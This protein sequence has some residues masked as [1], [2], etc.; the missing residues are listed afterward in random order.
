[1]GGEIHSKE[2]TTQRK[3]NARIFFCSVRRT[4][5]ER[6]IERDYVVETRE[7]EKYRQTERKRERARERERKETRPVLTTFKTRVVV[8]LSTWVKENYKKKKTFHRGWQKLL[9]QS[10]SKK[11]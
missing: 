3:E 2:K 5:T 10:K 9:T 1:M 7:R 8:L 11:Q 6:Q 4:K